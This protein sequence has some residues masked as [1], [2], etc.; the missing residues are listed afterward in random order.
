MALKIETFSN[1]TGSSAL[2][3]ALGHPLAQP[4]LARMIA[5]LASKP[6]VAL[7]D[8]LGF[9]Q[10]L[11]ELAEAYAERDHWKRSFEIVRDEMQQLGAILCSREPDRRLVVYERELLICRL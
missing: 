6:S 1:V 11:A 9:A 8:P 7:Y 5:K 2:F 3:K 10:T 4:G